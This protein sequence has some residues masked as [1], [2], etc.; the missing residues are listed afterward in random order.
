MVA[1]A[2]TIVTQAYVLLFPIC[3]K[4][5]TLT[6]SLVLHFTIIRALPASALADGHRTAPIPPQIE[7][8]ED[9]ETSS[10]VDVNSMHVHSVPS[11]YSGETDTQMNRY[12][13]EARQGEEEAKEGLRRA[14]EEARKDYKKGKSAATRKGK[15]ARDVFANNRDNP[16]VLGNAL[17]WAIVA[18]TLG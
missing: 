16:V 17:I 9:V 10:T 15:E 13:Q 2:L 11:N 5:R 4:C 6:P 12:E 8:T 14:E 1:T 18:G 7:R 3:L